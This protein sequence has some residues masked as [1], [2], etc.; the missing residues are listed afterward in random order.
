MAKKKW[1]VVWKIISLLVLGNLLVFDIAILLSDES[2]R[3]QFMPDDAYY[4]L[5]LSKSFASLGRWTF[6]SGVSLTS[7]FHPLLAYFLALLYKI[8]TPG[9][10]TFVFYSMMLSVFLS[11]LTAFLIW[12]EVI[13]DGH[14]ISLI[15]FSIL[16]GAQGFV[17]NSVSGMEW[18]L[19]VF[20][21]TLYCITFLR[22]DTPRSGTVLFLLG[23]LLSLAR[24]DSGLLPLSIFLAS[25]LVTKRM[26]HPLVRLSAAGLTG[27]VLAVGMTFLHNFVLTGEMIQSSAKIKLWWSRFDPYRVNILARTLGVDIYLPNGRGYLPALNLT[28]GLIGLCTLVIIWRWSEL[29]QKYP[30][31]FALFLSSLFCAGLYPV[32]YLQ[33]GVIQNWY[34]A[35]LQ[36]P[37]FVIL[38]GVLWYL[39][40]HRR[41][42]P[43]MLLL[44]ASLTG[45][46]LL[47]NILSIYPPAAHAPWPHQQSMLAAGRY[48]HSHPLDGK[49]GAWNAGIIG[50][51][52]GGHVIN[53]D[54]LVNNDVIPY[55]VQNQLPAY[56]EKTGIAYVIDFEPMFTVYPQRGGYDDPSFLQSLQPVMQFD[57][58]QF[59]W[60]NLILYKIQRR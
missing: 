13:R 47:V 16:V 42:N 27:S 56:L 39:Q 8:F 17:F 40:A 6:D 7:G 55:I 31:T 38:S 18:S 4:Y 35:N 36:I 12:L 15:V 22:A 11:V 34:T 29:T 20:L 25:V 26:A 46:H 28:F 50:Y 3:V 58:G 51:Y 44:I 24:T 60:R 10:E 52:E 21:G 14:V 1:F 19:V 9:V 48:L 49:V 53:L 2:L 30:R 32:L 37:T 57:Q 23:G 45:F 41:L 59:H 43:A 5:Q 54:G 33:A